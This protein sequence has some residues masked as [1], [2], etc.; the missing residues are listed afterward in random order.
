[1]IKERIYP[2]GVYE[3]NDNFYKYCKIEINCIDSSTIGNCECFM[4]LST[5][6]SRIFNARNKVIN[7]L[8]TKFKIID[9]NGI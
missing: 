2:G 3:I 8:E 4:N 5:V 7:K 9:K 1:M 6:K